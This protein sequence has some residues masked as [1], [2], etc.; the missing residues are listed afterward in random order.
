[1]CFIKWAIIDTNGRKA[2]YEPVD[3]MVVRPNISGN[4]ESEYST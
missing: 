2:E 1:M 3:R 4:T